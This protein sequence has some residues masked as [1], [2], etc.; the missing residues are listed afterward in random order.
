MV[1]MRVFT[2]IGLKCFRCGLSTSICI[3]KDKCDDGE[4]C[5]SRNRTALG[6]TVY[7]SGC[8]SS[9]KCGQEVTSSLAGVDYKLT[10]V[11]CNFDYCNGATGTQL[12]LLAGSIAAASWLTSLL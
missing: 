6:I 4:Q 5:Y 10:T 8:T 2:A 11:C 3:F 1:G 7:S 9:D 12:S